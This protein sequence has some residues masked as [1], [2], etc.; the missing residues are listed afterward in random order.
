MSRYLW[1]VLSALVV[2]VMVC[3]CHSAELQEMQ[4]TVQAIQQNAVLL[5]LDGK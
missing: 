1:F 3:W 2:S 5:G 4:H